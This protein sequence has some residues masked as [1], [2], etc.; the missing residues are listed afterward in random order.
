M[1]IK[2]DLTP[3]HI[4]EEIAKQIA[5]SAIGEQLQKVIEKEVSNLS[6]QYNN[7][8]SG[9]VTRHIEELMRKIIVEEYSDTIKALIAEKMSEEITTDLIDKLWKSAMDRY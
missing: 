3:E 9:I 6:H 1:D 4:N 2:V 5:K 8:F 7:P